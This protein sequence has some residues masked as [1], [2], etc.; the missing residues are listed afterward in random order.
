M[1]RRG[2]PMN[3]VDNYEL[4][5]LDSFESKTDFDGQAGAIYK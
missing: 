5:I 1:F 4:Q 3:F 2:P